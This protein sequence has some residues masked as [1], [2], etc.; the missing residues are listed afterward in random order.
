VKWPHLTL[1]DVHAALAYFHDHREEIN[2]ELASD[3]A[4]YEEQKA[5]RPS[6][7]V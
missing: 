4:W 2:A 6:A 7:I 3:V 1:S 5:K